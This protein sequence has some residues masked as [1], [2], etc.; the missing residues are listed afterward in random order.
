MPNLHLDYLQETL[1]IPNTEQFGILKMQGIYLFYWRW[2]YN[3]VAK[4]SLSIQQV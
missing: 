2:L 4:S 3:N 1:S